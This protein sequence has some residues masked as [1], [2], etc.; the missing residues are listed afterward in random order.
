[1][2]CRSRPDLRFNVSEADGVWASDVTYIATDEGW[3]SLAAVVIGQF[4]RQVDGLG[5]AAA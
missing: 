2:T 1:M 3:L 4:S 5:I